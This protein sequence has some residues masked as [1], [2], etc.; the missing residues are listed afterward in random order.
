M[1]SPCILRR[2][3]FPASGSE[4]ERVLTPVEASD[5]VLPFRSLRA[6][7]IIRASLSEKTVDSDDEDESKMQSLTERLGS[8]ELDSTGDGSL[9]DEEDHSTCTFVLEEGESWRIP[10]M[11]SQTSSVILL[12]KEVVAHWIIACSLFLPSTSHILVTV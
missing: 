8:S 4:G 6:S 12:W 10:I 11:A 9:S 2:F 1:S 3:L 5:R 7:K